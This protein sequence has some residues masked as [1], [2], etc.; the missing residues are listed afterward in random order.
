MPTGEHNVTIS[1]N[2]MFCINY[3]KT[4]KSESTRMKNRRHLFLQKKLWEPRS[5]MTSRIPGSCSKAPGPYTKK[6]ILKDFNTFY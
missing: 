1:I 4:E 2:G 6:N 5:I 3:A